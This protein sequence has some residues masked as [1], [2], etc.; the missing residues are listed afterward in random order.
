LP[1]LPQAPGMIT[2]IAADS[3]TMAIHW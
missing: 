3:A 2:S 1:R